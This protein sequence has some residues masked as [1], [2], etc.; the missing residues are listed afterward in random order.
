M[1]KNLFLLIS[2]INCLINLDFM[3]SLKITRVVSL[4][5]AEFIKLVDFELVTI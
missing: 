5:L 2:S 1:G 4:R 3:G